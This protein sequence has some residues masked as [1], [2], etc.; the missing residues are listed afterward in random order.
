MLQTVKGVSFKIE[1][2]GQPGM[3]F[4]GDTA[5]V[6]NAAKSKAMFF[7]FRSVALCAT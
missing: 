5:C 3:Q 7:I 1:V 2:S 6:N 4:W